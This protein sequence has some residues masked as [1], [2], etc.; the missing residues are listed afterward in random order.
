MSQELVDS[1]NELT[2]ETTKLLGMYT[3]SKVTIDE[4]VAKASSS[5]ATAT[6]KAAEAKE[7]ADIAVDKANVAIFE[8]ANAK[9]S[10]D[11][12]S[13]V[14]GLDTVT[15][16]VQLALAESYQ[17]AMT[18]AEFGTNREINKQTYVGS[19]FIQWG[20]HRDKQSVQFG[21]PVNKGCWTAV[22]DTRQN[23]IFLGYKG[24]GVAGNSLSDCAVVVINGLTYDINGDDSHAYYQHAFNMPDACDGT[25]IFN[26][27]LSVYID[28][29][30]YADPLYPDANGDPTVAASITEAIERAFTGAHKDHVITTRQDACFIEAFLE[31]V[32]DRNVLFPFGNVG[33]TGA[34]FNGI[35]TKAITELGIPQ[36]YGAQSAFDTT[37]SRGIAVGD[38]TDAQLSAFIGNPKNNCYFDDA[39]NCLVQARFRPRVIKGHSDYWDYFELQQQGSGYLAQYSYGFDI[40]A[41]HV[42]GSLD[43]C[44]SSHRCYSSYIGNGGAAGTYVAPIPRGTWDCHIAAAH[45]SLDASPTAITV[46][47]FQHMN[48]GLYHQTLNPFGTKLAADGKA[49]HETTIVFNSQHDCF[50]PANLL[51]AS[52][53]V[54]SAVSGRPA[55]LSHQYYDGMDAGRVHDL[56][57][58]AHSQ[59]MSRIL[60]DATAKVI[61]GEMR[62]RQRVPFT[63]AI[64][65]TTDDFEQ[66]L[67]INQGYGNCL[68]G[69][70]T[71]PDLA[72]WV[73]GLGANID[74]NIGLGRCFTGR[75]SI[76]TV[77]EAGRNMRMYAI[78]TTPNI[79]DSAPTV[80]GIEPSWIGFC[81]LYRVD[82]ESMV[83]SHGVPLGCTSVKYLVAI[84]A[85]AMGDSHGMDKVKAKFPVSAQFDEVPCVDIISNADVFAAT[86]PQG[87][88]G[89]WCPATSSPFMLTEK[90]INVASAIK[91]ADNGKTWTDVV[92]TTDTIRNTVAFEGYND[93]TD[94]VLV[95]YVTNSV[96]TTSS[97][98]SEVVSPLGDVVRTGKCYVDAGNR[99]GTSLIKEVMVGTA[100]AAR[101]TCVSVSQMSWDVSDKHVIHSSPNLPVKHNAFPLEGLTTN[102]PYVKIL[103]VVVEV[104]GLLTLQLNGRGMWHNGTN[105]G[106]NA[107]IPIHNFDS[108]MTDDNDVR[109]K[110][111]CHHVMYPLGIASVNNSQ[112]KEF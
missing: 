85:D 37:V 93:A 107:I 91:S 34:T 108:F 74:P 72:G 76:D 101:P 89:R 33:Y 1:V 3:D 35:A 8:A 31:K 5:A 25:E 56:R 69:T 28:Y 29:K 12:A 58:S 68:F 77:N 90:C 73:Y 70:S 30:T 112:E 9:A 2:N 95:R 55:S 57:L 10:A 52:G 44:L 87:T 24:D 53:T 11:K 17:Y 105:T 47:T 59:D 66:Y 103:P 38:L 43:T 19:G 106:D 100:T 99:L 46:C 60:A 32:A 65:S 39:L 27:D 45:A 80:L 97:Y 84:D 83:G 36:S 4:K 22:S 86:F 42:Q 23:K 81:Q 102:A 15:E 96:F 26:K 98:N 104:N 94:I 50:I 109:V 67:G 21:M 51:T 14:S 78:V 6:V 62:G 13:Q 48:Q 20:K 41:G 111:F 49:W 16:A 61:S 75:G 88:Q 54:A 40:G 63:T 7:S 18:K 110:T 92:L 79:N 71:H 64:I 82:R